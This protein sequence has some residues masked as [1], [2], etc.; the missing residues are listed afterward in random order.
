MGDRQKDQ[1]PEVRW[2]KYYF[3]GQFT[4]YLQKEGIW[5]EFSSRYTPYQNDV[6]KRKNQKIEQAAR[7]MLEEKSMPKF[8]W[9]EV[10]RTTV[11]LQIQTSTSGAQVSLHDIYFGSKP[12]LTHLRVF[13]SITYVNVPKEKQKKFGPEIR[14]VHTQMNIRVLNVITTEPKRHQ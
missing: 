12:N 9:A 3:S 5:R 14:V 13:G 8:Y 11:Y 4:S 6:A 7:A 10:V 2:Q 1:V